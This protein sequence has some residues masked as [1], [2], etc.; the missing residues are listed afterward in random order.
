MKRCFNCGETVSDRDWDD[1][2]HGRVYVCDERE[3]Q[4]ELR[5][6]QRGVVEQAQYEAGRDAYERYW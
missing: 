2:G 1:I 6:A 5:E 3:C 4:R